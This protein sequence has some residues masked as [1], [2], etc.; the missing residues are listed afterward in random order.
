[1]F[2]LAKEKKTRRSRNEGSIRWLEDKQLWQARYPVG[3]KEDGK[4]KYKS[5]YGKKNEKGKLLSQ[6]REAL[7]ALGKSE[8]V[9]PSGE[10]LYTWCKK[11]YELKK[12]ADLKTNT[13]AKYMTSF[14]RLK[15]Y[16]IANTKLKDLNEE[17]LQKF[18]NDMHKLDGLSE[19]TIRVTHSLINGAL[20]YAEELKKIPKN[21]ARKLTIPK[22]NDDEEEVKALMV[23]QCDAFLHQLGRRTKYYMYAFF[24]LNT[25][26]RPGEALALTRADVDL[27]KKIVK[28]RKTYLEKEKKVQNSPKTE[29]S[30][31]TVP[32][33]DNTVTLLKEYMLKQPK[34]K[35]ED[36]L[37]QTASGRRPTPS[38][39]RKRFKFAGEA[40]GCEWV[41]LHTMRHT[42]AS[43]LFAQGKDIKVISKLL[44]HAKIST[45]YDIYIHIINDVVEESIDVLNTDIKTPQTLPKRSNSKPNSIR[46]MRKLKKASSH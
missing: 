38:Y 12:E 16:D 5:I 2:Y 36:P 24:M 20:D 44:G 41:N 30:R 39:L 43:R 25:G 45:T 22:D 4:T 37:F 21:Y 31:R 26:L 19:E 33:P 3:I 13:Q 7:V 34:Q 46:E 27:K 6:M 18:Y 23:E 42:F 10:Q 14:A 11:W 17:M 29:S 32:I 40:I 28:V 1:V 9:E 35:P 8:Y 15:R